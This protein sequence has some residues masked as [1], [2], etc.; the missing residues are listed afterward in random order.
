MRRPLFI[1]GELGWNGLA[2]FGVNFSYHPIPYLAVD[3][4][5]GL[6]VAGWRVGARLR[7]NLLTGE[8]TP[9]LGA[10][11]TYSAG[12]AGQEI[13][14]ESRGEKTKLEVFG[15]PYLQLAGGVNYTSASGFVFMAT[16]G[17]AILLRERNT[18]YVSGSTDAYDDLEP[19]YEGGL[20]LSV[21]FGYAF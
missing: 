16:T 5:L 6:S 10:G 15:S 12:S 1:G 3:T 2:G 19:L 11:V 14:L 18:K 9:F 20:I 4:G 7:A 13:E 21:A 17:Y 8:W